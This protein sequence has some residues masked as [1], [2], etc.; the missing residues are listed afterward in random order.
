MNFLSLHARPI[1]ALPSRPLGGGL[2]SV[3][4]SAFGPASGALAIR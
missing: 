1:P 4:L 3:M 2:N